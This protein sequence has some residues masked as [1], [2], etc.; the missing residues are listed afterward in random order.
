MKLSTLLK[1]VIA[2]KFLITDSITRKTYKV[3][4]LSDITEPQNY[5]VFEEHGSKA[6]LPKKLLSM[7][8]KFVDN[9]GGNL[10]ITVK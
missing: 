3:D 4:Y 2:T 7:E 6:T 1:T 10:N 5:G 9:Y 8:V